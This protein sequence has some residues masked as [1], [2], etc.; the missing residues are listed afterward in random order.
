MVRPLPVRPMAVGGAGVMPV[1]P[2]GPNIVQTSLP[3]N[4]ASSIPGGMTLDA[5]MQRQ[6]ELAGQSVDMPEMRSPLQ[7]VAYAL[8]KGIQ[9]FQRGRADRD[10]RQGRDA[11]AQAIAH[12]DQNT[13]QMPPEDMATLAGLEPEQA[14][15]YQL[16][17]AGQRRAEANRAQDRTWRVEDREDDQAAA[18]ALAQQKANTEGAWKPSDIGSLRDDYTKAAASYDAAAPTWQSIQEAANTSLSPEGTVE[19]KGAADYNMIVG[20]AKLLDP[21]SVVRE[22]EVKSASMTG[23]QL[24]QLQGWLNQ[25]KSEGMLSDPVRQAIMTQSSSRVKS[26]HDQASQKRDWLKG[27]ATRHG[28]NP[29][30][31]VP[32]LAEFKD[33]QPA[34]AAQPY[35]VGDVKEFVGAD[36]KPIK[37]RFKG[38]DS[39]DPNSWEAAP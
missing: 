12:I 19:G 20:F 18:S 37:V 30:D 39:A 5:L 33:W 28:V 23:G 6:K 38:G 34:D 17:Q 27:V 3:T 32:P 9:G 25:W 21:N 16:A 7:G 35:Q 24:E 31:V 10:L 1:A 11:L 36:G 15:Q 14:M 4:P 29:D 26:Y 2:S 8:E 22:G 13:G